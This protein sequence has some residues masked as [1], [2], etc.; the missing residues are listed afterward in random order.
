MFITIY[1]NT[2]TNNLTFNPKK[3]KTVKELKKE[4]EKKLQKYDREKEKNKGGRPAK[5]DNNLIN[6]MVY[7]LE[8]GASIRQ[9]CIYAWISQTA[10]TERYR[11]TPA[12]VKTKKDLEQYNQLKHKIDLAKESLSLDARELIYIEIKQKKNFKVALEYLK[13]KD[14]DFDTKRENKVIVANQDNV[15]LKDKDELTDKDKEILDSIVIYQGQRDARAL[16][17]EKENGELKDRVFKLETLLN[18]YK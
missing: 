9:A 11:N 8:R 1:K 16:E 17:L 13:L 4:V 2:K 18:Q 15:W 14:P 12:S 10:F 3:M 6:D 7:K 5:I